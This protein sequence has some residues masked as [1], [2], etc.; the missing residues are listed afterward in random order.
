MSDSLQPMDCSPPDSSVHGI[1]KARMLEWVAISY[2]RGSSPRDQTWVSALQTDSLPSEPPGKPEGEGGEYVFSLSWLLLVCF[3][4]QDLSLPLSR[5]IL[6][7]WVL[8]A[9]E[10]PFPD[11]LVSRA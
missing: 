5:F 8:E 3:S 11:F 1:L 7:C 6:E 2:S 10:I 9:Q 4:N